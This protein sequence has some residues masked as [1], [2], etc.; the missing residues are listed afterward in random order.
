[1]SVTFA[2][3]LAQ[4]SGDIILG[5]LVVGLILWS[6]IWVY[7]DA[8]ARGKSGWLVTLLVMLVSWPFGLPVWIALRPEIKQVSARA[9]PRSL[10][11][12]VKCH[13]PAERGHRLCPACSRE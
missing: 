7:N 8:K 13:A 9:L 5:V 2:P 6:L 12:C 10:S 3:L 11:L 1:M 4:R